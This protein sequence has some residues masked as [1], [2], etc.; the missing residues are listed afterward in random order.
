MIFNLHPLWRW[1]SPKGEYILKDNRIT[2]TWE[3]IEGAE[4]YT[5]SATNFEDPLIWK[6]AAPPFQFPMKRRI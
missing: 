3:E 1:I 5:I 4:Y 6:E 2:L